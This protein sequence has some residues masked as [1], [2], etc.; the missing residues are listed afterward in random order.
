MRISIIIC[1]YGRTTALRAL[2]ETLEAQSYRNFETLI[3]DG[4][5]EPSPA[6]STVHRFLQ[7]SGVTL[8]VDLVASGT[9]LTRQ[10]NVGLD[11][12]K[13]ELIC[14][15]DDDVTL[16]EDFLVRVANI[17]ER[18]EMQDV[19]GITGYDEKNY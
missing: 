1:T 12:A 17:F 6:R 4:N 11:H 15:L 5:E 8:P 10:R 13:G 2:L 18:P 9:G 7:S 16:P 19:G 14:F 3:I